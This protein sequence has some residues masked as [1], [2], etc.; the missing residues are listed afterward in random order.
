MEDI[1]FQALV[2]LTYQMT[3]ETLLSVVYRSEADI[4]FI[5]S[6]LRYCS[7]MGDW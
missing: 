6:A 3:D 5:G 1:G 4:V 7:T 2:G